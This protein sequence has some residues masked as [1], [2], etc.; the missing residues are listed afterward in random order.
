MWKELTVFLFTG[1][2][3]GRQEVV[4]QD[5]DCTCLQGFHFPY[6]VYFYSEFSLHGMD[7]VVGAGGGY[8]DGFC[9]ELLEASAMYNVKANA[10]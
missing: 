10:R 9:E 3:E 7:L 6:E 1:M 5:G 4:F 8:R 2:K